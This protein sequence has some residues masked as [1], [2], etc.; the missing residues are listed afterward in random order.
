MIS[1]L[2]RLVGR[3][4]V[5]SSAMHFKL[6]EYDASLVRS[7]PDCIV[8]PTST[9]QVSKVVKFAHDHKI[10]VIARGVRHESERGSVPFRAASPSS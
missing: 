9:A 3:G 8:F 1:E 10:P 6:Y 2:V 7:K 5:L 4:N